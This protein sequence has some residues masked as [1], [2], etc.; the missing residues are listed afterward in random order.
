MG[1]FRWKIA[2]F[3]ITTILLRIKKERNISPYLPCFFFFEVRC[4]SDNNFRIIAEYENII[5]IRGSIKVSTRLEPIKMRLLVTLRP[6]SYEHS[7]YVSLF[8]VNDLVAVWDIG[9]AAYKPAKSHVSVRRSLEWVQSHR[10]SQ[11]KGCNVAIYLE[12]I[13]K[14]K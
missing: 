14:R 4:L 6:L 5:T 2:I 11:E 3:R 1:H 13:L 10:W 8:S 9:T 12:N 7:K